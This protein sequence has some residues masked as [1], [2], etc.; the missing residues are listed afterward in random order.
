MFK[1]CKQPFQANSRCIDSQ[2]A[3][4]SKREIKGPFSDVSH[5]I[6]WPKSASSNEHRDVAAG[7]AS[8]VVRD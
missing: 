2:S 7:P 8:T 4:A 3:F 5:F 6:V 1:W